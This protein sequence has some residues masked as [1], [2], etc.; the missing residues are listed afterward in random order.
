M[1]FEQDP[2]GAPG[3]RW[4]FS[5][6]PLVMYPVCLPTTPSKPPRGKARMDGTGM[7][8]RLVRG[9]ESKSDERGT[10]SSR[11]HST[12]SLQGCSA[13]GLD[14]L[15]HGTQ[16]CGAAPLL[17]HHTLSRSLTPCLLSDPGDFILLFRAAVVVASLSSQ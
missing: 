11:K 8:A 10:E 6:L 17:P 14:L 15:P 2:H 3:L 13:E 12:G 4:L 5:W 1:G 7:E 9:H 16:T